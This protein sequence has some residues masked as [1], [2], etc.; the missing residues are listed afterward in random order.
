[1]SR[2]GSRTSMTSWAKAPHRAG[3]PA[4]AWSAARQGQRGAAGRRGHPLGNLVAV[5]GRGRRR[6]QGVA[7]AGQGRDACDPPLTGQA[8][9]H[10]NHELLRCADLAVGAVEGA[11]KVEQGEA[12]F[13]QIAVGIEVDARNNIDVQR[14]RPV[15]DE[16]PD[17]GRDE[18][19]RGRMAAQVRNGRRAFVLTALG[20]ATTEQGLGP[21][22]CMAS[23]KAKGLTGP[24]CAGGHSRRW[25]SR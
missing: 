8:P 18:A 19:R 17:Q 1:M 6:P 14:V 15:A 3:E 10:G 2:A 5:P 9:A 13:S 4:S 23:A 7:Q 25:S 16:V 22:S 11:V 24:C 21:G 12:D 20:V